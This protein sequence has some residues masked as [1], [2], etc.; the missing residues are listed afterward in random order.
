M[1]T[2]VF[3]PAAL[4]DL[5]TQI[6]ELSEY[7]ISISES[8]DGSIQINIGSSTYSISADNAD[9]VSVSEDVVDEIETINDEAYDNMPDDIDIETVESGILKE[10]AK[11]LL[12]GGM[13]R[14][15]KKL[16]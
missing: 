2:L 14:L 8:S 1:D 4:V 5:L 9:E 15:T 16:L 6:E 11:T 13:V 3:T 7:D 10:I 12:V